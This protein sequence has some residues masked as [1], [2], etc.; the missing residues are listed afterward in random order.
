MGP[1]KK[2]KKKKKTRKTRLLKHNSNLHPNSSDGQQLG[3]V[4]MYTYVCTHKAPQVFK[5]C[6]R[7]AKLTEY[8]K[9]QSGQTRLGSQPNHERRIHPNSIRL[10]INTPQDLRECRVIQVLSTHMIKRDNMRIS[11]EHESS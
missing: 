2:K 4:H 9:I 10:S 6:S 8:L 5:A 3:T 11:P 1:F 7:I